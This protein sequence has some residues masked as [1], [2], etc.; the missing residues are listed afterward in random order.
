M[1]AGLEEVIFEGISNV[2]WEIIE[3][4]GSKV[5]A[6]GREGMG[7]KMSADGIAVSSGVVVDRGIKFEE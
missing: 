2:R 7:V 4:Y 3:D 1:E 6:V 5:G